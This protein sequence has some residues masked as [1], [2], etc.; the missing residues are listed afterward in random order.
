MLLVVG[1]PSFLRHCLAPSSQGSFK[2]GPCRLGF[3]GNQSQGCFPA[4][5]CRSPAHSPCH[6]H[7][8]CL[9]ERN[10]AVSCSVSQA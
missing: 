7:A 10:G 9:F 5:T 8:H 3:V 4:R 1:G 6:A 2:C